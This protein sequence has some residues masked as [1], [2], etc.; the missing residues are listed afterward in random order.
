M[1][2]VLLLPLVAPVLSGRQDATRPE[3][4]H[5]DTQISVISNLFWAFSDE[6]VVPGG[7]LT[8]GIWNYGVRGPTVMIA[9]FQIV[10][11]PIR[12]P[13]APEALEASFLLF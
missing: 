8:I 9:T 5:S 13:V 1:A 6:F 10:T 11:L 3:C 7:A 2:A 4:W 12:A